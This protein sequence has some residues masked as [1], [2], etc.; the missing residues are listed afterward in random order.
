MNILSLLHSSQIQRKQCIISSACRYIGRALVNISIT[1]NKQSIR[2]TA[3][4]SPLYKYLN[5]A[6]SNVVSLYNILWPLS[7]F[8]LAPC[9][10]HP[11]PRSPVDSVRNAVQTRRSRKKAS[12]CWI[13]HLLRLAALIVDI[14]PA[15]CPSERLRALRP[16]TDQRHHE[17]I[18]FYL[19]FGKVLRGFMVW[20][21]EWWTGKTFITGYYAADSKAI[22]MKL[23]LLYYGCNVLFFSAFYHICCP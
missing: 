4:P 10:D 3:W 9:S 1:V 6:E 14:S 22:F 12:L 18:S 16:S 8:L 11:A 21:R 7:L 5:Q 23:Y 13:W 20:L 2:N 15:M 19:V 17:I